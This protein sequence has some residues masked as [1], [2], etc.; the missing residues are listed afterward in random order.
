M[1]PVPFA[2]EA[3]PR[4][5]LP[6]VMLV[7]LLANLLVFGFELSLGDRADLLL[8]AY[9]AVPRE[10]VTGRDLPPFGPRPIQLTLLTSMFLHA[11]LLHL[12]SNML[13]LW[14]FG[15]N[16]EDRLGSLRFLVFYLLCGLAANVAQIALA[17]LSTVPSVGASGAIAGI[18][19]AYLVLFPHASIRVLLFIGPFFTVTRFSALLVIGLW[20]IIQL[21]SGLIT[22]GTVG[23]QRGG[24]A[25]WAHIGG[26][27]AGALLVNLF[28]QKRGP[29]PSL[30]AAPRP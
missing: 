3:G 12:A 19:G 9:G 22:L 17:P 30:T 25:F 1:L 13:Y 7:I 27:V 24:V 6:V 11:G 2:D 18:L 4:R 23:S 29:S 5:R 15:D 20:F 16:V 8:R 28:A 26:F 10:I 21:L 14:V